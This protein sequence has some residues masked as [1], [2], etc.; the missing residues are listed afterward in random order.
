MA[1]SDADLPAHPPL[2]WGRR[3]LF[4]PDDWTFGQPLHASQLIGRALAVAGVERV[5]QLHMR[6]LHP[7]AGG[8]ASPVVIDL[9]TLPA[10]TGQVLPIGDFEILQVAGDPDHLERG[11]IAFS[12]AGGRR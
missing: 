10:T 7:G 3:G 8:S 5:T 6:R 2:P 9:D 1:F 11:R 12:I 4:H